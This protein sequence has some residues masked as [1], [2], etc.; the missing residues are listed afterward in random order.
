MEIILIDGLTL[1]VP[2]HDRAEFNFFIRHT[3]CLISW[4][5]SAPTTTNSQFTA[6]K[7]LVLA[8]QSDEPDIQCQGTGVS[9]EWHEVKGSLGWFYCRE[10]VRGI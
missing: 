4:P 10:G 6:G 3:H 8:P 2:C 5:K 7:R 9:R 1:N